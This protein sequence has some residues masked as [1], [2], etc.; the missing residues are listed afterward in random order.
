MKTS[1]LDLIREAEEYAK[2]RVE[3][4]WYRP[5]NELKQ[6]VKRIIHETYIAAYKS[7]QNKQPKQ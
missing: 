4:I 3:E 5:A 6:A 2:G 1:E 7:A